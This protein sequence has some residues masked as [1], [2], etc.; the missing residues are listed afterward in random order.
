MSRRGPRTS[1]PSNRTCPADGSS[2]PETSLSKVDLPQPDGPT[3]ATNSPDRTLNDTSRS[4][5]TSRFRLRKRTDTSWMSTVVSTAVGADNSLSL[6][7]EADVPVRGRV[8]RLVD[9]TRVGEDLDGPPPVGLVVHTGRFPLGGSG[10][11]EFEGGVELLLEHGRR[12]QLLG[13]ALHRVH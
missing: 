5:V 1:S 4:A 6:R 2:R 7:G 13:G 9:H 12:R 11:Q 10:V 3:M 8:L